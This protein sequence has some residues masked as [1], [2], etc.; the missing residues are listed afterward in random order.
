MV[1][2]GA[3]ILWRLAT[4]TLALALILAA[5]CG[6]HDT[7]SR[8]ELK[9]RA[10]EGSSLSAEL[11]LFAEVD[12]PPKVRDHFRTIHLEALAKR[13]NE[14]NQQLKDKTSPQDADVSDSLK[15]LVDGLEELFVKVRTNDP[16]LKQIEIH[17]AELKTQFDRL[18]AK[19]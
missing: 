13:A 15:S 4:I 5:G 19:L 18:A 14:L 1:S 2:Q 8:S 3:H 10:Q 16:D 17:S 6:T 7:I 12:N 11:A 9:D